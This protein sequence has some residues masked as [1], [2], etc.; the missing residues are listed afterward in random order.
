MNRQG[1]RGLNPNPT[2]RQGRR[3][4]SLVSC[5]AVAM[6]LLL[7]VGSAAWSTKPG[8]PQASPSSS[9]KGGV[10]ES[11]D[12]NVRITAETLRYDDKNHFLTLDGHVVFTHGDTVILCPHA[13]FFTDK[14][15][16][17]C[18]G[19][20]RILQPGTTV[21]GSRLDAFYL[22]RRAV[23]TGNVQV[24]T[25]RG[26]KGSDGKGASPSPRPAA[27]KGGGR[28]APS[29]SPA[30]AKAMPTV[31]LANEMQYFWEKQQGDAIGNVKVRQ[32]D[33]RGFSDRAH[34][35]GPGN[36]VR[37]YSN[38]RYE[39]GERDWMTAEE[40]TLDLASNIFTARHGVE[41]TIYPS[42]SPSAAPTAASPHPLGDR[43]LRP[44]PPVVEPMHVPDG[45]PRDAFS[46]VAPASG[47]PGE[48]P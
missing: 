1:P 39:R 19:G 44:P 46:P 40:A 27:A 37:M 5:L 7:V 41:V 38:V 33:K 18:T 26:P 8:G 25:E 14:Q 32:G 36:L 2:P 12:M 10:N 24:V 47:T 11:A 23:V 21:T 28:T 42:Q 30:V 20:V 45:M 35:D 17:H 48:A 4:A 13:E 34:Y 6:A 3:R 29:S 15:V 9:P 43:I 22:E 16:G 31:I